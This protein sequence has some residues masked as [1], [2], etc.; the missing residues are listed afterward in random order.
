[1]SCSHPKSA[2][3]NACARFRRCVH[4]FSP[5]YANSRSAQEYAIPLKTDGKSRSP[6]MITTYEANALFGNAER[7]LM[8]NESLLAELEPALRA[9]NGSWAAVLL[10]HVRLSFALGCRD[11]REGGTDRTLRA[12]RRVHQQLSDGEGDREEAGQQP[13]LRALLRGTL[14]G[15][16]ALCSERRLAQNQKYSPTADVGSAGLRELLA[17]PFQRIARYPLLL[18]GAHFLAECGPILMLNCVPR[19]PQ[20]HRPARPAPTDPL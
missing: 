15:L 20:A 3:S 18:S 4:L 8:L 14:N 19:N 12:L 17:E 9:G 1:M 6:A 11:A 13:C 16:A 10:R 5:R 7:L 2:T